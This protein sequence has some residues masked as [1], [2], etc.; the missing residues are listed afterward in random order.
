MDRVFK[1]ISWKTSKNDP[2]II[3]EKVEPD[4]RLIE[5]KKDS[6]GF[7]D[8]RRQNERCDITK[9]QSTTP[10]DKRFEAFNYFPDVST[11]SK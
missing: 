7:L 8:F 3:K 2:K 5:L 1:P 9:L 4:M 10:H 11:K 6:K